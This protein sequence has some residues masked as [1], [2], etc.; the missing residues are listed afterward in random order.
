MSNG[1]VLKYHRKKLNMTQAEVAKKAGISQ[2]YYA[3]LERGTKH[4]STLLAADLAD[5]LEFDA[6]ELVRRE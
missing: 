3:M 4:A 6:A 2:P 5:A 1:E